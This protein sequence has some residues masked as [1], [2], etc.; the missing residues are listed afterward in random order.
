MYAL[1]ISDTEVLAIDEDQEDDWV[2]HFIAFDPSA[3]D[4]FATPHG[5]EIVSATVNPSNFATWLVAEGSIY[6]ASRKLRIAV[7]LPLPA[8]DL[9]VFDVQRIGERYY[10]C[11]SASN[12]WYY[13]APAEKWVPVNAPPALVEEPAG[14][15]PDEVYAL[16]NQHAESNPDMYK[17]FAVG[18]DHY[19]VG[20]LGR[21]LRLRGEKLD[22]LWIDSAVQLVHGYEEDGKAVICGSAPM[23]EIYKGTIEAGFERIFES[24]DQSLF[25]SAYFAGS[26][27]IGVGMNPDY[28]GDNFLFT[29]ADEELVPVETG[30]D[31]EPEHLLHLVVTG[32][33]LWA[34]DLDG[35]F[36]FAKGKWSLT[37]LLDLETK[38]GS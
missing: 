26:R 17:A 13:D 7:P 30:C 27:F 3:H 14:A 20:A 22:E 15:S 33:V 34:I 24:D 21:V 9:A 25:M 2:F 19:F 8:R 11:C 37:E 4:S 29:Y 23:V 31:R 1:P 35:I 36:R 6:A 12:V 28:E 16:M 10:V 32:E 18:E 5:G 38:R